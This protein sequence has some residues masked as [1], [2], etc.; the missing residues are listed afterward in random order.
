MTLREGDREYFYMKLDEHFPG[1]RQKY[2]DKYG[3]SYEVGSDNSEYLMRIFHEF[4]D[5]NGIMTG[6]DRIFEYMHEFPEEP[7]MDQRSFFEK[8]FSKFNMI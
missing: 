8:L 3:F 6:N 4:C 2:H 1:L 5:L 7:D